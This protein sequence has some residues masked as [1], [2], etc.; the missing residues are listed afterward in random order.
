M[1]VVGVN[2]DAYIAFQSPPHRRLL[3]LGPSS[4]TGYQAC[5]VPVFAGSESLWAENPDVTRTRSRGDGAYSD[6]QSCKDP[7]CCE[8]QASHPNCRLENAAYG[9]LPEEVFLGGKT[10][11]AEQAE[12]DRCDSAQLALVARLR[13]CSDE[14]RS[15]SAGRSVVMC[16][17]SAAV[18]T[19]GEGRSPGHSSNPLDNSETSDVSIDDRSAPHRSNSPP[20]GTPSGATSEG[21]DSGSYDGDAEHIVP[22]NSE[23]TALS[24]VSS[25][26]EGS[27]PSD[28]DG[29]CA[30][31]ADD[32]LVESSISIVS[33]RARVESLTCVRY[34]SLVLQSDFDPTF[35]SGGGAAGPNS[36]DYMDDIE[37]SSDCTSDRPDDGA[38]LR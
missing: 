8:C 37:Y 19:S 15:E 23:E 11:K 20:G 1:N 29:D 2:H 14:V 17:E 35:E 12:R 5:P 6:R 22:C 31:Y 38:G 25:E 34:R 33:W 18:S 32:D 16:S 28:C 27:D 36:A 30:Y 13:E 3:A 7:H 4:A 10:R 24:W 21:T 26:D 9:R